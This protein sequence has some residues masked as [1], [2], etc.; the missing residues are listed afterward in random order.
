MARR[1]Q[2]TA[3]ALAVTPTFDAPQRPEIVPPVP[4]K[5][6]Q[7]TAEQPAKRWAS[8]PWEYKTLNLGPDKDSPKLRLLRSH[9]FNQVQIRSDEPLSEAAREKLTAA[10]WTER[11]EEGNW[12]KQ[13]PARKT[14]DGK[15]PKPAW[16]AVSEAERLFHDLA[17]SIRTE[18][19]LEPAAAG[20]GST[21]PF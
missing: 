3:E 21:T 20:R 19:G 10:G 18:K 4:P 1:K 13:L 5:A 11:A 6:Q 12:T 16:P 17:T 7:P 9:R 15:E 8:D 2:A 14:P